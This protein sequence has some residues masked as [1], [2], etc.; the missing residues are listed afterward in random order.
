MVNLFRSLFSLFQDGKN[1]SPASHPNLVD[2]TSQRLL[3]LPN[4]RT[5]AGK[6]SLLRVVASFPAD[7][8]LKRCSEEDPDEDGHP[9]ASLNMTLV[10]KITRRISPVDFLQGLE[11]P[12]QN[13]G[14]R[15]R[16]V[17]TVNG[18]GKR[19]KLN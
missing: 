3:A 10:K 15:K 1:F 18:R 8:N 9:I 5:D 14:K 7:T 19:I 12:L 11:D 17:G 2:E 6:Y 13:T 4:R 16:G